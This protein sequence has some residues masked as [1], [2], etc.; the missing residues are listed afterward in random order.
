MNEAPYKPSFRYTNEDEKNRKMRAGRAIEKILREK[1]VLKLDQGTIKKVIPG[2]VYGET[3]ETQRVT[4]TLKIFGDN[5]EFTEE[6]LNDLVVQIFEDKIIDKNNC[7][8]GLMKYLQELCSKNVAD[9]MNDSK[10]SSELKSYLD[11]VKAEYKKSMRANVM[12]KVSFD[13]LN[14][15][16]GF[17]L[18]KNLNESQSGLSDL[19]NS[20]TD[21]IRNPQSINCETLNLYSEIKA[22]HEKYIGYLSRNK[23]DETEPPIGDDWLMYK[24]VKDSPNDTQLFNNFLEN[25]VEIGAVANTDVS[26]LN[27]E[28]VSYGFKVQVVV[29]SIFKRVLQKISP[30]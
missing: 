10:I 30:F 25:Q 23:T 19:V 6:Q 2:Y 11:V 24:E 9:I 26:A 22:N 16:L 28:R 27:I 14:I 29:P 12:G 13:I 17:I 15:N 20:I 21:Y 4:G 18:S 8:L 1:F 3:I 7:Y 5:I